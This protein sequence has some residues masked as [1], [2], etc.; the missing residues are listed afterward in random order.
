MYEITTRTKRVEKQYDKFVNEKIEE[1]LEIL[2][3]DPR[4]KL[5]AHKL[6]GNLNGL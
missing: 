5:G 6:K 3:Q 1:K 2:K 4:R